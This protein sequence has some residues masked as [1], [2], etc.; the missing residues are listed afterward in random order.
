MISNEVKLQT[1][2]ALGIAGL[3]TWLNCRPFGIIFFTIFAAVVYKQVYPNARLQIP[4]EVQ[5]NL[6]T[7]YESFSKL[8]KD[9]PGAFCVIMSGGLV[10]VAVAGHLISGT[11]LV[12][13]TLL[14]ICCLCAKY[15]IKVING[16]DQSAGKQ[17]WTNLI[18]DHEIDEFLPDVTDEQNISLLNQV[19]ENADVSQF[20]KVPNA[21]VVDDDSDVPTDLLLTSDKIPEIEDEEVSSFPSSLDDEIAQLPAVYDPIAPQQ[22]FGV[23]SSDDSDDSISR[24]LNFNDVSL[25]DGAPRSGAASSVAASSGR[26]GVTS[27]QKVSSADLSPTWNI[28][29]NLWDA[30]QSTFPELAGGGTTRRRHVTAEL[31][32]DESDFELLDTEDLN[33]RTN[34]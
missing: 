28:V 30:A 15:Q 13:G 6:N 21:S 14:G 25:P 2:A 19:S 17:N 27:S 7:I 33:V 10:T 26:S 22:Q 1:G 4:C 18:A 23:D 5:N 31:S 8:R 29:N 16:E 32:S 24:G 34:S 9:K 3:M 11:W 12:L 20:Y